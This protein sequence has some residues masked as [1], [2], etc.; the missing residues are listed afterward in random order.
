M[1]SLQTH[2]LG[3]IILGSAHPFLI[4][5]HHTANMSTGMGEAIVQSLGHPSEIIK[6]VRTLAA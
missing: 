1:L 4:F 2:S 5:L 3:L 6:C